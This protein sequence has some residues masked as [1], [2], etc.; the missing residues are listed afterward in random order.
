MAT[1]E[2]AIQSLELANAITLSSE[3]GKEVKFPLSRRAF[4]D[5]LKKYIAGSRAKKGKSGEKVVL[6]WI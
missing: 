5:V 2:E 4:D 6:P 3:K 1:G